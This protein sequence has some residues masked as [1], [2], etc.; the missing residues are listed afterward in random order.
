M[1]KTVSAPHQVASNVRKFASELA[2]SPELQ[3]KLGHVHA[4]YAVRLADGTWTFGPSKFVGYPDNTAK[5]YLETYQ[6]NADGRET[7]HAL[8]RWFS[9]VDLE[10]RLGRELIAALEEFLARWGRKPRSGSRISVISDESEYG[11]APNKPD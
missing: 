3:S 10:S 7:E 6:T 11:S 4:W 5:K 9:E 2:R 1:R 8:R